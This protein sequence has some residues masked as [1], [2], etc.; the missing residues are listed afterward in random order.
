MTEIIS[1]LNADIYYYSRIFKSKSFAEEREWR[2]ICGDLKKLGENRDKNIPGVRF[3]GNANIIPYL[4]LDLAPK[5]GENKSEKLPIS[6]II[7]GPCIDYNNNQFSVRKLLNETGFDNVS[8]R[9]SA[10]KM[11]Y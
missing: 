7:I 9:K 1:V 3:R 4:E 5:C 8:I 11:R 10:I 6:E 2:A